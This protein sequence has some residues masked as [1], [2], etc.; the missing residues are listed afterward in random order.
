MQKTIL[1]TN[2]GLGPKMTKYLFFLL[3]VSQ[4]MQG[5]KQ[6]DDTPL[7]TGDIILGGFL[8]FTGVLLIVLGFTLF[9]P[10]LEFSP[11]VS[12]DDEKIIV[13]E[14]LFKRTQRVDWKDIKEITFKSFA[15]SVLLNDSNEKLI[16]LRTSAE[17]SIDVKKLVREVA[18]SKSIP[19][20]GG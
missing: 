2:Y 11:K 10:T 1:L 19:T 7:T 5:F 6:L 20:K 18:E 3:G 12:V 16:L 17:G 13:R 15:L 8:L 4:S 14:D 9:S